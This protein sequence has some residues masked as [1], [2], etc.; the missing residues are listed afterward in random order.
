MTRRKLLW[1]IPFILLFLF[2]VIYLFPAPTALYDEIFAQVEPD[3]VASL[4][5]FRQQH[6]PKYYNVDGLDW[7]YV[8]LGRGE[9]AILFLHGMIGAY[10]IWWQQM[11]SLQ[12]SYRIVAV[13]SLT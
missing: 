10:D 1:L 13:T 6:P 7:E 5:D 9:E 4:Q 3:L 2:L 12:E 11:E 8:V